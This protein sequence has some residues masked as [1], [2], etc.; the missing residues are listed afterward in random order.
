MLAWQFEPADLLII[1]A[2]DFAFRRKLRAAI[3]YALWLVVLVKLLLPPTLALPTGA[4]W[5]LRNRPVLATQ[6]VARPVKITYANSITSEAD[7]EPAP[8]IPA[9]PPPALHLTMSGW[10]LIASA[11]ISVLLF[12]WLLFRWIQIDRM[13]RRASLASPAINDLL[14]E[15]K[16]RT[17][18][19]P[20]V[21]VR[22]TVDPISPAV[23]GLFRPVVLLPQSLVEK[24]SPEQLRAVLLHELVHLRRLDVWVNFAQSLLQIVHWWNP[25]L[26]LANARIRRVREEAVDDAVMVT[27]REDS[28]VYAPT[29]LGSGEAGFQSSASQPRIGGNPRI[30]ERIAPAHRTSFEQ[31]AEESGAFD[32]IDSGNRGVHG[33]G[34][35]HGRRT[36]ASC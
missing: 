11:S 23:C 4:A 7:P 15:I 17:K 33:R 2:I 27:L 20:A 36:R 19:S 18:L 9:P 25:L 26:W 29:L 16:P 28:E 10:M 13:T 1:F 3:R 32:C 34:S 8:A 30:K 5:W 22:I 35:S 12:A 24:L 14:G 31:H 6:P 21:R